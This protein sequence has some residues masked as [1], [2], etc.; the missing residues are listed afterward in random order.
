MM[1][2]QIKNIFSYRRRA[3]E[4]GH[5]LIEKLNQQGTSPL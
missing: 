5:R 1:P 4:G 2:D 3:L